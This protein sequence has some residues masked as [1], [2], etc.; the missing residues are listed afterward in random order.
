MSSHFSNVRYL[1][2]PVIIDNLR[3]C[4]DVTSKI[5]FW[6]NCLDFL[7][8]PN[9]SLRKWVATPIDQI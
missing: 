2:G 5:S 4:C 9:E 8:K 1:R 7:N 3:Q 6:I